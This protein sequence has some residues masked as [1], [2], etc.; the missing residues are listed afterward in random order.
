MF[1]NSKSILNPSFRQ[2]CLYSA[3]FKRLYSKQ[4]SGRVRL[5]HTW[6]FLLHCFLLGFVLPR[7]DHLHHVFIVQIQWIF[8]VEKFKLWIVCLLC[9]DK[10]FHLC[11]LFCHKFCCLLY[12]GIAFFCIRLW[13]KVPYNTSSKC[14]SGQI[15]SYMHWRCFDGDVTV[16]IMYILDFNCIVYELK[17]FNLPVWCHLGGSTQ[18]VPQ[19]VFLLLH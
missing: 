15:K 16:E 6:I 4:W 2:S 17:Y 1:L 3:I 10:D 12:D 11:P 19:M 9:F 18:V 5:L 8:K 7:L 13:T 14:L